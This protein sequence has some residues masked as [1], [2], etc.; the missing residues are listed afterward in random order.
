LSRR[1]LPNSRRPELGP[2]GIKMADGN[3][4]DS[5]SVYLYHPGYKIL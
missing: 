1:E 5:C 2:P 3:L 4:P